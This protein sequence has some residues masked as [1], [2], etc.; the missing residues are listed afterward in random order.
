MMRESAVLL[1]IYDDTIVLT[2]RSSNLR[3]FTGHVCLPG[4]GVESLDVGI[5]E[6]AIREFN[7]EIQYSGQIEALFC[8]DKSFSPVATHY[9][10]PIVAR[11]EGYISGF[12]PEEVDK[13][14]YLPLK[15]LT[16][17]LFIINPN[18]PS[19]KHNWCFSYDGEFIWGLTAHILK[20]FCDY[21]KYLI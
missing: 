8:L 7:E 15:N 9:I 21:K 4:G 19:I 20:T 2:K 6:A 1:G 14:I 10:Y 16:H 5:T 12:S 11:L 17:E 3:S 18:L 13:I